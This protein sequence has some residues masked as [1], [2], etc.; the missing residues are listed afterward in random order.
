MKKAQPFLFFLLVIVL[1]TSCKKDES[2]PSTEDLLAAHVWIGQTSSY[3]ASIQGLNVE[4]DTLNT[5]STAIEFKKES[6]KLIFYTRQPSNGVLTEISQQT[7]TL[8]NN[9]KTISVASVEELL[10]GEFG[11]LADSLG[12]TPPTSIDIEKINNEELILKGQFQQNISVPDF[13][14]P[15]PLIVSYRFVYKAN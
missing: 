14:F 1:H 3:N 8:S 13:P 5:D 6:K 12:I 15:V 4:T 9:D 11:Y 10:G 7:Y 2:E